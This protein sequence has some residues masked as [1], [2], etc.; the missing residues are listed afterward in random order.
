MYSYICTY[1]SSLDDIQYLFY[2]CRNTIIFI[3]MLRP[4]IIPRQKIL[5]IIQVRWMRP[6]FV[7]DGA[8]KTEIS[9]SALN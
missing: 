2:E 7:Y 5:M 6:L 8:V 3:F 4:H 1:I 9:A